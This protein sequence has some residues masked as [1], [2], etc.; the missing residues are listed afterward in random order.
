[1]MLIRLLFF[2]VL[3]AAGVSFWR[4]LRPDRRLQLPAAWT[5]AARGSSWLGEAIE[6]RQKIA[7]AVI[8]GQGGS[9]QT[10]LADVDGVLG[11]LVEIAGVEDSAEGLAGAAG[12]RL[13][14]SLA[15]LEAERAEA[16]R[17]LTEAYAVLVETAASD[18]DAAA[19]RL[20]GSLE[21]RR[22]E[23]RHEVEARREINAALRQ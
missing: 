15:K 5:A 21:A 1:M 3:V 20:H 8:A 11:R 7:R 19:G 2:A 14:D 4:F 23:L 10:L 9:G 12:D 16:V 17:W 6:L 13:S 18:F 22:E